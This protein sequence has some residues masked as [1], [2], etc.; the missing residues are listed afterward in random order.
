VLAVYGGQPIERQLRELKR[1]VQVVVGTP[2]RLLDHLR[3][4]SLDLSGVRY[5]VLD[6]ADE[7]LDMGFIEDIETVLEATPA[8]RQT[9]L[10]SATF[11]PRIA[12]LARK[13]MRDPERLT[14]VPE[15][16]D[17]PLVRQIG[18]LVPRRTS[19]RRWGASWT[20]R[21]PSRRSCSAAPAWRW[22]S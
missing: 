8:S 20:W 6:E 2:G 21:S 3:R 19:W 5:V 7:M 1:G 4:G 15:A 12:E 9:A 11:P 10:F 14:V 18:Y 16:M 17:T 13:H 22:T